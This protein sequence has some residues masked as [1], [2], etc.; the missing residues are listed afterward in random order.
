M[1]AI[2]TTLYL[3]QSNIDTTHI[4]SLPTY[5]TLMADVFTSII[6]GINLSN[7][8]ANF[9]KADNCDVPG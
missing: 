2:S 5:L 9:T 8:S 7:Y 1:Q 3:M 6:C 4:N